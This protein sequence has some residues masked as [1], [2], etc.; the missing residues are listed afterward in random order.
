MS[1]RYTAT[2]SNLDPKLS[3]LVVEWKNPHNFCPE[4]PGYDITYTM[5]SVLL[6]QYC[7]QMSCECL[8]SAIFGVKEGGY[9]RL[10]SPR[11]FIGCCTCTRVGNS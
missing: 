1:K 9:R 5:A 10:L 11:S 8:K 6:I 4:N 3:A 2:I 7:F